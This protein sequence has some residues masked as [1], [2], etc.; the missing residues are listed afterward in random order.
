METFLNALMN[1]LS[2][3]PPGTAILSLQTLGGNGHCELPETQAG[4]FE[5]FFLSCLL[6]SIHDRGWR[7]IGRTL[8]MA[9]LADV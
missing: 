3:L 5:P 2:L 7:C 6:V 9:V 8:M 1:L 4:A